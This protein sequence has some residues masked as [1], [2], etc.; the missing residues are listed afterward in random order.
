MSSSYW[1]TLEHACK[2]VAITNNTDARRVDATG[3]S[4]SL[5]GLQDGP[6]NKHNCVADVNKTVFIAH[7]SSACDVC[8]ALARIVRRRAR[9]VDSALGITA[10]RVL[11]V[12]INS[13]HRIGS[14]AFPPLCPNI[15]Q[16]SASQCALV[17][18]IGKSDMRCT[19]HGYV[20]TERNFLE[21]INK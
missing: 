16:M 2:C 13:R 11:Q 8:R 3:H 5:F 18:D 14:R 17:H 19:Y 15:V 21:I 12:C 4:P 1:T 7:S 10:W 20:K 9:S 6:T